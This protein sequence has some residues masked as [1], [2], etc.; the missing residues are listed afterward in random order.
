MEG[1]FASQNIEDYY[2]TPWDLGYDRFIRYN[3]DLIGRAALRQRP[4]S[5]IAVKGGLR[6]NNE[7]VS[8]PMHRS[9]IDG[10]DRSRAIDIPEHRWRRCDAFRL[11]V[12]E[13]H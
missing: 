9:L 5:P 1:S 4:S 6:W 12:T 13:S 2:Q 10:A 8:D 7:N 3:H 11:R